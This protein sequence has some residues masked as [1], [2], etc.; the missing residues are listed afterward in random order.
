MRITGTV[1]LALLAASAF[2]EPQWKARYFYDE[3]DT[4]LAIVDLKFSSPRRGIAA[5]VITGSNDSIKPVVI[6]TSDGGEHWTVQPLKEA[7]RSL[8]FL[9]D[10]LGWMVTER[11]IWKTEESGRSWRKLKAPSGIVRVY[12]ADREQGWAVGQRKAGYT[13]SDG[14]ATWEKLQAAASPKSSSEFTTY[15]WIEFATKQVGMIAGSSR[16]P[17]RLGQRLPDWIDP[18]AAVRRREWPSLTVTLDTRDG[19]KTWTPSTGSIFGDLTR[20]RLTPDGWGVGLFEYFDEFTWP[21]EIFSLDWKTGKSERVLRL[22]DRAITDIIIAPSGMVYAAGTEMTGRIRQTPVPGKVKML[23]SKDRKAWEPLEVDYRAVGRR[24]TLA[25][26]G[27]DNVWAATD[28]GMI[29]K[30]EGQ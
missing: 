8:F 15:T 28:T 25:I 16:P 4:S 18:E 23:R 12:F 17:R 20:I 6:V 7:A 3:D 5:G 19:G 2:A 22:K 10:S 30:L 21:S 9:D 24:V 26:A 13:T 27:E 1:P 29:L 14:G 11:G